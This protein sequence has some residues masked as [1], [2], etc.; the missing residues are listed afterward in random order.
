LNRFEMDV[1]CS[2]GFSVSDIVLGDQIHAGRNSTISLARYNDEMVVV[3]QVNTSGISLSQYGANNLKD[4]VG[5]YLPL[6][7]EVAE[8]CT[9]LLR[10]VA[11]YLTSQY[12]AENSMLHPSIAVLRC[13]SDLSCAEEGDTQDLCLVSEYVRGQALPRVLECL[14]GFWLTRLRLGLE[15]ATAL[16]TLH[17]HNLVH[18]SVRAINILVTEDWSCKLIN[19]GFIDTSYHLVPQE[20]QEGLATACSDM[21]EFGIVMVE[22][23][24]GKTVALAQ[25][26][27]WMD[28]DDQKEEVRNILGEVEGCPP[29]SIE[30]CVQCMESDP[31]LR[32][33]AEAAVEW[34]QDLLL[35]LTENE[36]PAPPLVLAPVFAWEDAIS[37]CLRVT[38]VE[39]SGHLYSPEQE[40]STITRVRHGTSFTD[41]SAISSFELSIGNGF[42]L[43]GTCG[44]NS[45]LSLE[46]L[47][48][49][50]TIRKGFLS[51][52]SHKF[53]KRFK[54][55]WFV[56]KTASLS[57]YSDGENEKKQKGIIYFDNCEVS[58]GLEIEG[59]GTWRL[60]V[61]SQELQ[62]APQDAHHVR[63][64]SL[65]RGLSTFELERK[66]SFN[67]ALFG[68]SFQ[69]DVLR[70]EQSSF[71]RSNSDRTPL[72]YSA[73]EDVIV[74]YEFCCQT[75]SERDMWVKDIQ[76]AMKHKQRYNRAREAPSSLLKRVFQD[77]HTDD[78]P[79]TIEHWL[80]M[81]GLQSL[82]PKFSN[83]G[84]LNLIS[85]V[86]EGLSN[87]LLDNIGIKA[88]LHR[89]ILQNSIAQPYAKD[90]QVDVIEVI[91]CKETLMFD[92]VTSYQT[93]QSR[94]HTTLQ[95][96]T[97]L[98]ALINDALSNVPNKDELQKTLID[99]FPELPETFQTIER[100]QEDLQQKLETYLQQ[101]GMM[102][103]TKF[104][105]NSTLKRI[106]DIIFDF[107]DMLLVLEKV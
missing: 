46:N 37:R 39:E 78:T 54:R 105:E 17:S 30:L 42:N 70:S 40:E 4:W 50:Q 9:Y 102:M 3:K 88:P 65:S 86:E 11:W 12:L 91:E 13:V 94:K 83:A 66:N 89:K 62:T 41:I 47:D 26:Y 16:Q 68:C 104:K 24:L 1:F 77:P 34:L 6:Y 57:W 79:E 101:A 10:P 8:K 28:P 96:L 52:K 76:T 84:Y 58:S 33:P 14:E 27:L 72:R 44:D 60:L 55:H 87:E 71:S 85:L 106:H 69:D 92:I 25:K 80:T 100:F 20:K 5:T 90:L 31:E 53:F 23:L 93:W 99:D 32:L 43:N 29:S 73:G 36:P 64:H 48:E 45:G 7:F 38:G 19:F 51:K 74:V 18:G 75:C 35:E 67:G 15:I 63:Q 49:E 97:K 2:E 82:T 61:H 107:L 98:H 103:M 22:I 59:P 56:L 81:L 21:F 95:D